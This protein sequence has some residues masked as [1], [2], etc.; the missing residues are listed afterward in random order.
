M[1]I[2]L[3]SGAALADSARLT[4]D[5]TTLSF[6]SADPDTAPSIL[7]TENP[8]AAD[9]F[10]NGSGSTIS[11][12]T[13]LAA[14]DLTSGSDQIAVSQVEWQGQGQGFVPGP[15][16]LSKDTPQLVGQWTGKV[17]ERGNL[18]FEL[19]NSWDYATGVYTQ[20]VAFTLITY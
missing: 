20:S 8:V 1:S 17:N 3:A 19:V 9:V 7:A 13:A 10:V 16:A 6:P 4:L 15:V 11:Q 18:Q 2:A 5:T 14:G 12:L